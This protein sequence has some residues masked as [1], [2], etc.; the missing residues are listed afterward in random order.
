MDDQIS[1]V[2]DGSGQLPT[3]SSPINGHSSQC[4]RRG[5][6]RHWLLSLCFVEDCHQYVGLPR[7]KQT[8]LQ[9]FVRRKLKHEKQQE[10]EQESDLKH[11]KAFWKHHLYFQGFSYSQRLSHQPSHSRNEGKSDQA[12]FKRIWFLPQGL[13]QWWKWNRAKKSEIHHKESF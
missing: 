3:P 10:K 11:H 9:I 8:F 4:H 6:G 13:F 12:L 2:G 1:V 5:H 7:L